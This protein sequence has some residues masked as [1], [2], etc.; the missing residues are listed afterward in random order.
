MIIFNINN[1]EELTGND[2]VILQYIS[3]NLDK[4]QYMRVR[5]IAKN[6]HVS[7]SSV[8]RFIHRIGYNSFPEFKLKITELGHDNDVSTTTHFYGKDDF[9]INLAST[10]QKVVHAMLNVDNIFCV[11]MGES[12]AMAEYAAR[13]L[14]TIG[15]NS[16][17]VKDPFY[18]LDRQIENTANDLIFF[19]SVSGNTQEIIDLASR[20]EHSPECIMVAITCKANSELGRICDYRLTYH[21]KESRINKY[22][23]LTS[24]IPVMYIIE[25]LQNLL[26]QQSNRKL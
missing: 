14:S 6:A 8:M 25:W 4:V 3:R 9:D 10:L 15:Y 20:I 12:G 18:P 21:S 5:D 1:Y 22:Y 24:Q 23:D 26:L 13:K 17:A 7:S 19:F 11:G 16:S 2:R